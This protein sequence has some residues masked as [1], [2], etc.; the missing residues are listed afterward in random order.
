MVM[1]EGKAYGLPIVAFNVDYS[2]CYQ[3]GV[4]TVE[5]FDYMAMAKETIQL[6]KNYE[7]RKR[8]GEEAKLSLNNY[9]TNDEK[10]EMWDNLFKVINNTKGF[11]KLKIKVEKKYYNETLAKEHIEKHFHYGQQFNEYFKCH[12]F[13]NFTSLEYL[14]KI[15]IC[16]I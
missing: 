16:K 10:V 14:N 9:E 1:N 3:S 6:L 15:E 8:K 4:I 7:Y 2:P 12:S 11:N 5:M 13:E